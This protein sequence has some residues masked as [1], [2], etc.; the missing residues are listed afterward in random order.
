MP[1][2]DKCVHNQHGYC[3][4]CRINDLRMALSAVCACI[5]NGTMQAQTGE[6]LVRLS[7]QYRGEVR[8]HDSLKEQLENYK[9]QW[10]RHYDG[11]FALHV[12]KLEAE[13]IGRADDERDDLRRSLEEAEITLARWRE[14]DFTPEEF[15]NL[16]HNME[17]KV[18]PQ[19]HC[20]GCEQYHIKLFGFSPITKSKEE[21][22]GLRQ[23]VDRL[24]E[25]LDTL[26]GYML[27][28]CQLAG[29]NVD[30]PMLAARIIQ[31]TETLRDRTA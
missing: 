20:D 30:A 10:K 4:D 16:C 8:Q 23:T 26:K 3:S 29:G 22:A 9:E 6:A 19:A 18:D 31:L 11:Q 15:Q 2:D 7:D 24:H 28:C 14:G 17:G 1:D 13:Y 25:E 12:E 21:V 5:A 27:H